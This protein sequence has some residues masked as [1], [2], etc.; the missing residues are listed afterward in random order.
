MNSRS[1]PS[2]GRFS[3]ERVRHL[4]QFVSRRL[5][6]ERLPQVA[7]SLTFTTVLA[8]VPL[9]TIAFAIFTSFPMFN[10]FR[11]TVE[12]YFVQNLIPRTIAS[13]TLNYLNQ[14]AAKASQ[15]SAIG[16][17]FLAATV[18]TMLSIVEQA[19]NQIWRVQA[20]RSFI[21]R[22]MV[23]WA[24]VTLGPLLV[25]GSIT[26]TSYLFVAT[27]GMVGN[28]PIV[29]AVFY[30]LVSLFLTTGAFAL[31]YMI[32]PN[33][34]IDW[35]DALCGGIVAAIAFEVTKRLFAAFIAQFPTYTMVYGA[36]A[37]IPIFLIW[38]YLGWLIVLVGAVFTAALPVIKY[39]RWWHL[40]VP[41]S[42]FIDGMAVLKVL[43]DE[44]NRGFTTVDAELI[45][46]KTRLGFDES[47]EL[48]QKMMHVGWVGRVRDPVS[49]RLVAGKRHVHGGDR[50][51]LLIDLDCISLADVF[52]LF[53]F[54]VPD[55]ETLAK[56]VNNVLKNE[57]AMPVAAYLSG[58]QAANYVKVKGRQ[59]TT[60]YH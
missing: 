15:L 21:Q 24:A 40:S 28:M 33:R 43:H 35:R 20:Q 10:V 57:L 39:E 31:L 54:A 53:A 19:F 3:L 42:I 4:L 38:I 22:I 11:K 51:S 34:T 1:W 56:E 30:T 52:Q 16:A 36:L 47:E 45:R 44:R 25:G 18:A 37:A 9:V 17:V 2:A 8:L 48:L 7:G 60:G 5:N 46:A 58:E 27:S 50:W 29:G 26:V 59:Q 12:E 13:T 32:V 55:S 23:Y 6:E 49:K 41:G 14:F